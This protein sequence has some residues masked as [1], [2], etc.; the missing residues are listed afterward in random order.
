MHIFEDL[1]E[2]VEMF[3]HDIMCNAYVDGVL[4]TCIECVGTF[5]SN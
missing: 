2:K 1:I 5:S 4:N 3:E